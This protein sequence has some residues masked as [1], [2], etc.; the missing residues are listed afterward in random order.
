MI[1]LC[2]CLPLAPS[3]RSGATGKSLSVNSETG[4]LVTWSVSPTKKKK[5]MYKLNETFNN[6]LEWVPNQNRKYGHI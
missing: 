6:S 4:C 1:G 5:E 2:A 3:E